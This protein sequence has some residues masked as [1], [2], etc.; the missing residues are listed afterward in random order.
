M[1]GF[2]AFVRQLGY[3]PGNQLNPLADQ[4]DGAVLDNS[5]QIIGVVARLTRG[6]IDRPFRVNQTNFITKTGPAEAVRVNALNEAKLQIYEALNNGAYEAVVQ[7][8]VPAAAL[9]SYAIVN[10][11]GTPSDSA[12]NT[13]F[14]VASVAPTT[15]YSFYVMHHD[16]FNDGFKLSFHADATLVGSAAPSA[17][18]TLRL[19][20]VKGNVLHEFS[21]SLDPAAKDDFGYSRYLP[22]VVAML[23]NGALEVVVSASVLVPVTSNAYGRSAA[24]RDNWA[25]SQTLLCFSEGGTS[26]ATED[27][28]RVVAAMRN[29][30][31][32]YGYLISGGTQNLTLLGKL[33]AFAIDAN[34]PMKIDISG[35]LSV[36]AAI[37]FQA[38]LNLDSHYIHFNWAPLEADDP[39]NGGRVVWG[40]GGLQAGFSC[41]RNARVNAKGFAPKNWPVA[42]KAWPLNRVSVRQL[43]RPEEQELSDLARSQINPVI[44]EQY[45]GGGRYVFTDVLTSAKSL[46]SYKKLQTVAEMSLTLDNW[47]TLFSKENLLLPMKEYIKRMSAFIDLMLSDAQ[48]SDWLVPSKN[49]PGNAAYAFTVKAS[50]VRPADVAL[51]SYWTSFDGVARQVFVQ[52]TLVK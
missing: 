20:D 38:S 50:E 1:S 39:L 35:S 22:D 15:G 23:S 24:G 32:S 25:T 34:M 49:L 12:I 21:G 4:T 6:R 2:R 30:T 52:Q 40:A 33:A 28:D 31:Q 11:S 42:G 19:T 5:D 46:V 48:A 14:S 7:R 16:C 17:D 27:Y 41:A 36:S 8:I 29:T 10:F 13:A 37:A 47:V 26:Y 43:V 51:I 9:K 44:Y 18:I 3:Q 45:N